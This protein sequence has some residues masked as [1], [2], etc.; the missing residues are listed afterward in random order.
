MSCSA[1]C[2]RSWSVC[3]VEHWGAQMAKAFFEAGDKGLTECTL[4]EITGVGMHNQKEAARTLASQMRQTDYLGMMRG[5]LYVLLSNT[6][7]EGA[8]SVI[9]RFQQK[10]YRSELKEVAA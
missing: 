6:D 1:L 9:E 5:N 4:L 8:G 10:G 3:K 2:G 7:Q